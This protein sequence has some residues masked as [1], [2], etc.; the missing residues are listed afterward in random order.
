MWHPHPSVLQ[1]FILKYATH[2]NQYFTFFFLNRLLWNWEKEE[3]RL[4]PK[5]YYLIGYIFQKNVFYFFVYLLWARVFSVYP[6]LVLHP[7]RWQSLPRNENICGEKIPT[8]TNP[9]RK[10]CCCC[11]YVS[12]AEALFKRAK[13]KK[14]A[15]I[16]LIS[17]F[18]KFL[19]FF[20]FVSQQMKKRVR[21]FSF[22]FFDWGVAPL[23]EG[24]H[25]LHITCVFVINVCLFVCEMS[26]CVCVYVYTCSAPL[27]LTYL[28]C[29]IYVNSKIFNTIYV[30]I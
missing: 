24:S 26:M 20:V 11:F 13:A 18:L 17:F 30:L 6:S 10:Y 3:E 4:R 29:L 16:F 28:M 22:F 19:F 14:M 15:K 5:N 8:L 9:P 27:L 21:L 1:I 25:N 23:N 12:L 2:K 7:T